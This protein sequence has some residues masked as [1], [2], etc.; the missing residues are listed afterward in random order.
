MKK[1]LFLGMC[2]SV[3]LNISAQYDLNQFSKLESKGTFP[4]EFQYY[5]SDT[6]DKDMKMSFL[7][8]SGL[9]LFGSEINQ[10]LDQIKDRLLSDFPEMKD[11]ISIFVYKSTAPNIYTDGKVVIIN[12]GLI[13]KV[14]NES[15]LAFI[16]AH[17]M[18]HI[19][20]KHERYKRDRRE[21][22][23]YYEQ[24]LKNEYHNK[25][26]TQ[27][28]EADEYAIEKLYSKSG[29][30]IKDID[31][32]F[33]LWNHIFSNY[34][35]QPFER[36]FFETPYYTFPN[37]YILTSAADMDAP[38]DDEM[39]EIKKLKPVNLLER[40][41]HFE[42]LKSNYN[43]N[44]GAPFLQP[45]PLFYF[46]RNLARFESLN[47]D[48]IFQNFDDLLYN[49]A[50]LIHQFPD[51][52]FVNMIC[53]AA[54]Y[55]FYIQKMFSDEM[56]LLKN[57]KKVE[58]AKQYYHFFYN[59]LSK[60]ELGMLALRYAWQASKAYPENPY[61]LKISKNIIQKLHEKKKLEYT[62]YSD[63]PMNTDVSTIPKDTVSINTPTTS[64]KG[65]GSRIKEKQSVK[66][67]PTEKFKTLNYMLVE[68]RK[69]SL[70]MQYVENGLKEVEDQ[71]VLS[72]IDD[73]RFKGEVDNF[74][75]F[76]PLNYQEKSI[77]KKQKEQNIEISKVVKQALNLL[78]Y[79]A[80]VLSF[81]DLS[82]FDAEMYN[83]YSNIQLYFYNMLQSATIESIFFQSNYI[84]P[85]CDYFN[86]ENFNFILSKYTP[87]NDRIYKRIYLFPLAVLNPVSAPIT[88]AHMYA[89]SYEINAIF[90]VVN[91][92][93]SKVNYISALQIT[94]YNGKLIRNQFIYDNYYTIIKKK[95]TKK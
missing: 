59:K 24:D 71:E 39:N 12:L 48:M 82:Q 2:I 83:H 95:G 33:Y 62:N 91:V 28:L 10:Y 86:S 67:I 89:R 11:Q 93:D 65:R 92:L 79:D 49:T 73:K 47:V 66:I 7:F 30:S 31:N 63:Y 80:K 23:T 56:T 53:V 19:M 85:T 14:E 77:S 20:L 5:L 69:D 29:Y 74:V 70:F 72:V 87:K 84:K 40:S 16:I 60:D 51:N 55:D 75:V 37:S 1:L 94:D 64:P 34:A 45:E 57:Y 22:V 21:S 76:N 61:F 27:E 68:L 90:L 58:E 8:S 88:L 4:K 17:E 26:A 46:I 52:K 9:V 43:I 13:N 41:E 54:H 18:A 42:L 81:Q 78:H 25:T 36:S 6:A 50:V 32:V 3:F 35:E 38:S 15:E 44:D